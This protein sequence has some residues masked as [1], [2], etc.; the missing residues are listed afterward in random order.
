VEYK[1]NP[2]LVQTR[3]ND[4][5]LPQSFFTQS[6]LELAPALIG[7]ELVHKTPAGTVAGIIVETEVYRQDDEASHSFGG[8][9]KRNAV[10]F[11]PGGVAYIYFTYGMH[12]CF[13]VVAG[14]SGFAEA[15]LVRAL[16]PTL[17]IELMQSRR[18]TDVLANLCSGPGK[19]VQALSLSITQNGAS[20]ST[21]QLHVNSA[22]RKLPIA[23]SPRIGITRAADKPWRFFVPDSP[24]ITKHRYNKAL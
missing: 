24:F 5:M 8:L 11:G 10:M 16:E 17:G 13:N 1:E 7:C 18:K 4:W 6:A 3:Y 22:H 2:R 15:V 20:L 19:L 9:T 14:E 21:P 12:Y 23:T